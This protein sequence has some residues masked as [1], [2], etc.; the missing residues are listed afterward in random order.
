MQLRADAVGGEGR[1]GRRRLDAREEGLV[2][3]VLAVGTDVRPDRA[4]GSSRRQVGPALA[5][6][7]IAV[8]AVVEVGSQ[9]IP[10]STKADGVGGQIARRRAIS[11]KILPFLSARKRRRISL[12]YEVDTEDGMHMGFWINLQKV[13]LVLKSLRY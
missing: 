12:S 7:K 10:T 9:S 5:A 13:F 8:A 3:V 11:V 1:G 4:A 2:L 6:G